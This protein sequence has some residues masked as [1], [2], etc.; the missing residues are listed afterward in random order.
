MVSTK[1]ARGPPAGDAHPPGS[2]HSLTE[3]TSLH[4][5]PSLSH[6]ITRTPLTPPN[7]PTYPAKV[8]RARTPR[9]ELTL[10]ST[11]RTLLRSQAD[12]WAERNLPTAGIAH[13]PPA[14][15]AYVGNLVREQARQFRDPRAYSRKQ[16]ERRL[17]YARAV[18][19]WS[20]VEHRYDGPPKVPRASLCLRRSLLTEFPKEGD[21]A[22]RH[23]ALDALG[24]EVVSAVEAGEILDALT[25][26]AS[27]VNRLQW[28]KPADA[29]R[30]CGGSA[31]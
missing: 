13:R 5:S 20:P 18:A 17:K 16:S 25:V 3:T 24:M 19:P 11:T 26:S 6:P 23:R 7:P 15:S 30:Y 12:V 8:T 31:G 22:T 21:A 28:F 9:T 10:D 4:P 29:L 2:A 27:E 1:S 14:L